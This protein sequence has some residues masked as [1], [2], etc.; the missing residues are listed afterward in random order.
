MN[1]NCSFLVLLVILVGH[2]A[3]QP[4]QKPQVFAPA[5]ISGKDVFGTAFTSDGKTVYFCETDPEVKHIQI[6]E[7]HRMGESW[8]APKAA[9]FSPGPYRDIDPFVTQ[10]GRYLIFESNRPAP[11]RAESRSDFDIYVMERQKNRWSEPRNLTEINSEL[12]EVFA[13][14]ADDGSLIFGS[15]RPGGKGKLDIYMSRKTAKGY[16]PPTSLNE[17]NTDDSDGNPAVAPN[18]RFLIFSRGGDL[19]V[20][21]HKAERWSQPEK[22]SVVNTVDDTE[23]A[24]AFSPDGKTLFYTS[25]KFENG[26]RVKPGTI[27]SVP[28]SALG[29]PNGK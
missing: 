22:L 9:S 16:G 23:Y 27:W 26:K 1:R 10:D 14:A 2:A 7:S 17:L 18:G 20:S 25:T 5:I 28:L 12:N 24:P 3:A 21:H 19:F 29:L 15:D 13:T 8:S 6:M 11:G 4:T